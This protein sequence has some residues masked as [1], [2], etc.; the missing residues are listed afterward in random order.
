MR[1]LSLLIMIMSFTVQ[2][3][4][5]MFQFEDLE[6][7]DRRLDPTIAMHAHAPHDILRISGGSGAYPNTSLQKLEEERP[8][9]SQRHSRSSKCCMVLAS[10][11]SLLIPFGVAAM[12][13]YFH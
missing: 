4:H 5:A 8:L 6:K 13:A 10:C 2:T 3:T 12:V 7:Q 11:A 1:S 9:I